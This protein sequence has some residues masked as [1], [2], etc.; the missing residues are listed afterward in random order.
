MAVPCNRRITPT[1]DGVIVRTERSGLSQQLGQIRLVVRCAAAA[2]EIS[3]P[4]GLLNAWIL[5]Q[6]CQDQARA[7]Y[8]APAPHPG[9][10][11]F[12]VEGQCM[13]RLRSRWEFPPS[14]LNGRFNP[15]R[16]VLPDVNTLHEP[17]PKDIIIS[18]WKTNGF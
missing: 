5:P 10:R 16:H 3:R 7:G 14:W 6:A 18:G 2:L 15:A 8:Q 17:I 1:L 11:Q 13:A 4:S 9:D 12:A